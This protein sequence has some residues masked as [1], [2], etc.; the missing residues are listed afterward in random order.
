MDRLKSQLDPDRLFFI[1]LFQKS[2]YLR[3]QAVRAGTDGQG[4]DIGLGDGFPEKSF[5][6]IHRGVSVGIGLEV[7]DITAILYFS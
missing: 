4:R 3:R 5:Q 2:D 6:I 7:G 1:Y